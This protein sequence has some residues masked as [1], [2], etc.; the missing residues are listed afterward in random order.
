MKFG[1]LD[2]ATRA[3]VIE[4][5][6]HFF[7]PMSMEKGWRLS[8]S[9]RLDLFEDDEWHQFS[10]VAVKGTAQYTIDGLTVMN[11]GKVIDETQHS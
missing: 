11:Q 2:A 4:R 9:V 3:A 5:L 8:A 10:V 1:E 6:N 7:N